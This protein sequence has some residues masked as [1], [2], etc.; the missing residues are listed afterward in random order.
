MYGIS[1]GNFEIPQKVS[2][3][4]IEGYDFY[5]TEILTALIF[6]KLLGIF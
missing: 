6:S 3:L 5:N 2:S 1:K 4:Y